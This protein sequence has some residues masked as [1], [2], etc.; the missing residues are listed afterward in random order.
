[1]RILEGEIYNRNEDTNSKGREEPVR[2]EKRRGIQ[3]SLLQ[4]E[5]LEN[6]KIS[7]GVSCR[8]ALI[9]ERLVVYCI[10]SV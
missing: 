7:R 5:T 6:M 4:M 9:R 8:A 1:M 2:T 10:L 3:T